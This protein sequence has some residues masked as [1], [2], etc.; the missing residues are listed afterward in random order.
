MV[1]HYVYNYRLANLSPPPIHI[2]FIVE[3]M[4]PVRDTDVFGS[5]PA[6][7]KLTHTSLGVS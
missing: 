2:L 4:F 6:L 3:T 1:R 7:M 5:V